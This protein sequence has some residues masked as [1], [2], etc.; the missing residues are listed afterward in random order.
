MPITFTCGKYSQTQYTFAQAGETWYQ[1]AINSD[2]P[3][4]TEKDGCAAGE[5]L[6]IKIVDL[7]PYQSD[8]QVWTSGNSSQLNLTAERRLHAAAD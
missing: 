2:D 8:T 4:T 7:V 1:I 6:Q 3:K 5:W